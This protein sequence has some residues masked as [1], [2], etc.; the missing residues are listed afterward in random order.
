[1]G[2]MTRHRVEVGIALAITLIAFLFVAMA[3]WAQQGTGVAVSEAWVRPTIGQGRVT[4]AYMRIQNLGSEADRLR[5]ASSPRA[6][7]VEIHETTMTDEGVMKMRPID[8]G[9]AIPAGESVLLTPGG[10]HVMV[11]GLDGDLPK[12]Q[13]L[14]LILEFEKAGTIE[15]SVP[16]GSAPSATDDDA[17]AADHSHY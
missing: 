7:R 10:A 3:V 5:S 9:L 12:G 11:M 16:A 1:M 8:G 4:A 17:A 15:V 14:P 13:A 6:A 2:R